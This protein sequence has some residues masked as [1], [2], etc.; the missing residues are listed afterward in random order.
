MTDTA[1]LPPIDDTWATVEAE[2]Q[3][4]PLIIRCRSGL[5][6][7]VGT[8]RWTYR[9]TVVWTFPPEGTEGTHGLP[10]PAQQEAMN[11]FEDAAM[12]GLEGPGVAVLASVATTGGQREWVWYSRPAAEF[13]PAFN[14]ALKGHPRYPLQIQ[15]AADPQWRGYRQLLAALGLG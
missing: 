7:Q 4:R 9:L 5:L 14:A 10:S 15:L 12:A 2:Q 1:G 13:N 8:G 6:P 11:R 3:G